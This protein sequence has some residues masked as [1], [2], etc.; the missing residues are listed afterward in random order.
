MCDHLYHVEC[1]DEWVLRHFNCPMDRKEIDL[2]TI[3]E[4]IK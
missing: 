4:F 1:I 3:K 2:N